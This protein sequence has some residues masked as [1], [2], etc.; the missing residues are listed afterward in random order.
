MRP[1]RSLRARPWLR[2]VALAGLVAAGLASTCAP[3]VAGQVYQWK[4]AK[5][6]THYSDKPPAGQ[7]F[8]DRRIDNRGEPLASA[9]AV[10]TPVEN[11][12]CTTAKLNLSLLNSNDSVRQSNAD[13]TP[14]KVL[15]ET[16]RQNQKDLAAAAVKAYCTPVAPAGTGVGT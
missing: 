12:Q 16:E 4:D 3:A 11:P 13:G 7:N 10:G 1:T 2:G 9:D 5:G 15:D 6:V 8:K 14:G